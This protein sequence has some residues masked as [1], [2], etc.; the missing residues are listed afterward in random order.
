MAR[1]LRIEFPGALYHLTSRGNARQPIFADD[2]DRRLFLHRLGEVVARHRWRCQAYCL[3]TNHYHLLVET[4]EAN[5][6]RGMQRLNSAYSQGFN[7][8]H[9]RVGHVLQ[10]R[11]TGILVERDG[12][13]LELA[14]YVVLNPVRAGI[15]AAPEEYVWSSLR[16]TLG[17]D[18]APAWLDTGPVLAAFGSRARYLEHVR[19][20]I[21][22]DPPW[23]SLRGVLLGSDEFVARLASRVDPR[24][25]ER[26]IPRAQRLGSRP[27]LEVLFAPSVRSDRRLRNQRICELTRSGRFSA[28]EVS[29]HLGLHYSTVSR[30]V[31][32]SRAAAT[33]VR[34]AE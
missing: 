15:V 32:A 26:E 12:H 23:S 8:R 19:A 13:H 33:P 4:P 22:L 30:I 27:P 28:A 5:V 29:R 18:P 21:G 11:F 1:P 14:R 7:S 25:V 24:A 31:A 17:L 10:G 34:R 9:E 3:M 6:S 16:A 20:G 2:D